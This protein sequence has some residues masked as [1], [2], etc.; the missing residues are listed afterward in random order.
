VFSSGE[1]PAVRFRDDQQIADRNVTSKAVRQRTTSFSGQF[2]CSEYMGS[3][4]IHRGK[5][6]P[7]P[8][9]EALVLSV[10]QDYR[11][12]LQTININEYR[13]RQPLPFQSPTPGWATTQLVVGCAGTTIEYYVKSAPRRAYRFYRTGG[14]SGK[15][16]TRESISPIRLGTESVSR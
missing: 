3:D 7:E 12:S 4:C 2:Q 9:R 10:I 1:L 6:G 16:K 14:L 5:K 8:Q 15:I 13:T 11:V